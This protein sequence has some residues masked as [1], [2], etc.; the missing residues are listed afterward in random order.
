MLFNIITLGKQN[1]DILAWH[2]FVSIDLISIGILLTLI[3]SM[4][5]QKFQLL[6]NW[7]NGTVNTN[8]MHYVDFQKKKQTII[9]QIS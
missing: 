3:W 5:L 2:Y 9:I 6:C 7:K 1:L 4:F 8:Y